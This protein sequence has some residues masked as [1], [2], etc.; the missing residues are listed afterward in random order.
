MKT[1]TFIQYHLP[2]GRR[3]E[4]FIRRPEAIAVL[5]EKVQA[6]GYQLDIEILQTGA[7]SMT[8][9]HPQTEDVLAHE[10]C[11]N[12]PDV[13]IAVDKLITTAAE[14]LMQIAK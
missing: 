11:A 6:A 13:L 2:N 1:I 8:A 9:T 4:T 10:I 12:S 5:A 14:A 7:I 3:S